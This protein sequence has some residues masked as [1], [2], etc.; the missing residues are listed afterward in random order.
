MK[1]WLGIKM[2]LRVTEMVSPFVYTTEAGQRGILRG[3]KRT[4]WSPNTR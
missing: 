4:A 3:K 1:D 2:N